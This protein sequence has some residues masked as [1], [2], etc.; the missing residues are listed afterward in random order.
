MTILTAPGAMD[1]VREDESITESTFSLR[2]GV[3]F[4]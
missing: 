3:L 4:V 1:L 2:Y